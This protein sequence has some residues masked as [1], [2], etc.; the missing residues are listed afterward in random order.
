M[1]KLVSVLICVL[2]LPIS[3]ACS[4]VA[5]G[6]GQTAAPDGYT[7]VIRF[8]VLSDTHAD[9]TGALSR[10]VRALRGIN[11]Y[12]QG[13]ATYK[14]LDAVLIAGDAV[15]Y[16]TPENANLLKDLLTR[17]FRSETRLIAVMGNHDAEWKT[18][19]EAASLFK[20]MTG[21][22]PLMHETIN[23]FHFLAMSS[24]YPMGLEYAESWLS[25][26]L[27]A[28]NAD[29]ANKPIFVMQHYP[30]IDMPFGTLNAPVDPAAGGTIWP[31]P[32]IP[33]LT[34]PTF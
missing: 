22:D 30:L 27:E 13:H 3:M 1:K 23:G 18:A 11:A 12:A 28:A 31:S 29:G 6:Q 33:P 4:S 32:W 16:L 26:E 14:N 20:K 17:E 10:Y 21:C 15:Q 19:E 5:G 34:H 25:T 8:A 9:T 2:L 24:A 7:P